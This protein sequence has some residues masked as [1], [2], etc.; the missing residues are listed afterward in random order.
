MPVSIRYIGT[1]VTVG[2]SRL[3]FYDGICHAKG[4]GLFLAK[5]CDLIAA[6]TPLQTKHPPKLPPITLTK[7]IYFIV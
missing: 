5:D 6:P 1:V 2:K 4:F 7:D 3:F